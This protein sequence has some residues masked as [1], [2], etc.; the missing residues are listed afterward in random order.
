QNAIVLADDALL[1]RNEE[2]TL[3]GSIVTTAQALRIPDVEPERVMV[4]MSAPGGIP[5]PGFPGG[6]IP[7]DFGDEGFTPPRIDDKP[8][9]WPRVYPDG[10][11]WLP[12]RDNYFLGGTYF[13]FRLFYGSFRFV[14][15][16][17]LTRGMDT[18]AFESERSE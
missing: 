2:P 6:P 5:M 17:Y 16:V 11:V 8:W 1:A 4:L 12:L 10:D 7:E 13:G 9:W 3:F 15:R 14:P 18:R